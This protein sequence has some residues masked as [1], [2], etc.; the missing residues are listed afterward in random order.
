MEFPK[1]NIIEK[2]LNDIKMQNQDNKRA[3]HNF[4]VAVA[5][6]IIILFMFLRG[7]TSSTPQVAIIK[8][9]EVK[10][11]FEAVKPN[12]KSLVQNLSTEPSSTNTEP[13]HI[14]SN[15]T[16]FLQTQIDELIAENKAL[17]NAYAEASDSL[18]TA[19]YQKAVEPKWFDHT[20]DDEKL[21]A[22]IYGTLAGGEVKSIKMD[23]TIKTQKIEA[24]KPK[25]T[26]LRVLGGGSV[27]INKELNQFTYS[28]SVGFQN[29]KGNIIRG[30][31]QKIGSQDYYLAGYEFSILN[32]KR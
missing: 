29:K 27:G 14:T 23:Y 7:C 13:K 24:P 31:Y 3:K 17:N 21:T 18:K 20:F 9:P 28:A 10:G 32:W 5:L 2:T 22:N 4:F 16:E 25:E 8:T 12:Q 15:E 30:Q 11:K 26:F 1:E 6:A 19:M